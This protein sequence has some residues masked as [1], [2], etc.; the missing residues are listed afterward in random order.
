MDSD[1]SDNNM[2]L[3]SV[4]QSP[5]VQRTFALH[6]LS[7]GFI[8]CVGVGVGRWFGAGVCSFS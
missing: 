5:G 6:F 7:C 1:R 2:S 3:N 8:V 4:Q